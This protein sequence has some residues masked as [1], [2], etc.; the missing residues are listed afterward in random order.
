MSPPRK[1]RITVLGSGTSVGVPTIGCG[2]PVCLSDDPRDK[3]LRPS[4]LVSFED[5]EMAR[6]VLIDTTPDLRQQALRAG[7]RRL[8]AILFTHAHADHIMGLD[9][10]R[11]FNYGRN[12]RIPAYATP[13]SLVK[14]QRIFPYAF[15]GEAVHPGGVPRVTG[16]HLNGDGVDLFGL[17]FIPVPVMHGPHTI[18]GFRFGRAAYLTDQSDIPEDS[19]RLLQDL[20]VLF[21]DALRR[22]PHPMHSTIDQALTWVQRLKPRRA[23]FTHICHDLPHAATTAALPEHVELAHD[24]LRIEVAEDD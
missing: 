10:I 22:V 3:R 24:D 6:N 17:P 12:D 2:C 16:R 14:I 11:P 23:Y 4:I 18:I 8:D 13:E 1:L 19:L 21:L 20:D 7:L 15:E 5:G 9:D